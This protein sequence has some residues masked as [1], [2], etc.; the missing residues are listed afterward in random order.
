MTTY[1]VKV[2]ASVPYPWAKEYRVEATGLHTALARGVKFFR[3]EERLHR[4]Q[5]TSIKAEAQKL[6]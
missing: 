3:K 2:E 4:K 5:I 1:L 6:V